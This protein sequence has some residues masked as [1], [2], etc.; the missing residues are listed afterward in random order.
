[1]ASE[2]LDRL[3]FFQTTI[4]TT[5]MARE[6]DKGTGLAALR[7]WVG[8]PDMETLAVGDTE[9]DLPMFRQATRSFAPSHISCAKL[10]HALGCR[11]ARYPYQRGLLDIA[12]TLI[13]ED[14][15]SCERCA[16]CWRP[17]PVGADLFVD[18]LRAADQSRWT[19]LLRALLDPLAF[20]V[21]VR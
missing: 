21:F 8:R 20:Q 6:V 12:R 16:R 9:P 7:E 14:G 11:I 5:I 3:R 2:G 1:M 10:A 19:S 4:D 18:L 17:G 13:H 15:R